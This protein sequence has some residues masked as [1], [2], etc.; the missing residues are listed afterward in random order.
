ML[1]VVDV[2]IGMDFEKLR[3]DKIDCMA[4]KG[5]SVMER[6]LDLMKQEMTG[7]LKK[8]MLDW[9]QQL[10]RSQDEDGDDDNTATSS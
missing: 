4:S 10:P 1:C 6:T 7:H 8:K 3:P 2:Q 9:L 5:P